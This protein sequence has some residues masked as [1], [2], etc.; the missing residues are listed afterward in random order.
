MLKSPTAKSW[1]PYVVLVA[2]AVT[3]DQ[4]VKYLVETGLPFQE[5]VDLVPF[6]AL[7]RTYNT[8]IAFSMFSSFG[9]TGLVVIAAFV[10]AFV[11]YLAA[12]TPPSHVLT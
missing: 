9:D 5:K 2:A 3:L 12:R 11:L 10:V 6:L 8:G 4:W 1:L 7:Y